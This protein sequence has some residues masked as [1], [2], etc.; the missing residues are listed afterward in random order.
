MLLYDWTW[1]GHLTNQKEG[2]VEGC[3]EGARRGVR[4]GAQRGA[5]RDA[6]RG[7]W[8]GRR[9][10]ARRG[11]RRVGGGV[12]GGV[13]GGVRRGVRGGVGGG[14]PL[15][16]IDLVGDNREFEV[17]RHIL[18]C[19]THYSWLIVLDLQSFITICPWLPLV[20]PSNH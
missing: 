15:A 18:S 4:R 9:R 7:A 8:R 11:A 1:W 16:T 10:G 14:V 2:C 6:R 13:C 12:R 5:R 20:A 19:Y 17:F 3:P